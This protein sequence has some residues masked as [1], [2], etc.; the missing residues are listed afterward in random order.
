MTDV[1][2]V[3]HGMVLHNELISMQNETEMKLALQ[4]RP[5]NGFM[6]SRIGVDK[7]DFDGD[8]FQVR[9]PVEVWSVP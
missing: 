1:D 6:S 7:Q 8:Q 5:D 3:E 9:L 2:R 4:F